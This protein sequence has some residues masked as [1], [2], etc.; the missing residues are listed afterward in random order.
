[1]PA[2]H[3]LALPLHLRSLQPPRGFFCDDTVEYSA[4]GE[5]L[6]ELD[7]SVLSLYVDCRTLAS[8]PVLQ[9]RLYSCTACAAAA[10]ALQGRRPLPLPRRA[11]SSR[12]AAA[13]AGP[14]LLCRRATT[15]AAAASAPPPPPA[16]QARYVCADCEDVGLP[17][18]ALCA[19]CF[20]RGE[21]YPHRFYAMHG[22]AEEGGD[23]GRDAEPF[24]SEDEHE[25][26]GGGGGGAVVCCFPL[27]Q[28]RR[29]RQRRRA[30]RKVQDGGTQAENALPPQQQQQQQPQAPPL[31]RP[32]PLEQLQRHV[33][34]QHARDAG[35]PCSVECPLCRAFPSAGGLSAH[36]ALAHGSEGGSPERGEAEFSLQL[37]CP[38]GATLGDKLYVADQLQLHCSLT[39]K[40]RRAVVSGRRD[41]VV[42][43]TCCKPILSS[44]LLASSIFPCGHVLHTRCLGGSHV[45]PSCR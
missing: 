12:L 19:A 38:Q 41:M 35:G 20:A 24:S 34:A 30:T 45:C 33:W 27:M 10:D 36:F 7:C 15:Q 2:G 23:G 17:P 28:R 26:G 11:L 37:R 18:V 40:M 6:D 8:P 29:E 1:M 22:A 4:T 5:V 39:P 21:H 32:L 25:G 42:C 13:A 31:L 3:L 43:P 16:P 14:C 44:L 9:P